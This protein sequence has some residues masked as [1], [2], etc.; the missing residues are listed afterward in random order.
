[1]PLARYALYAWGT[2]I[3][4]AATW[5]RGEPWLSTLRHIAKEGRLFVI[6][7]GMPLR[8][9]DIPDRFAFKQRFYQEA[10]EWINAGD[11]AIVNPDGEFIAG[12]LREAEG[13]LYAEVDPAQMRGP[14][15][16]LDV[17]GHYARPDVFRLT[18]HRDA[19]PILAIHETAATG[20]EVDGEG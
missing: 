6:G 9:A 20:G 12:P 10:G 2:Q 19:R 7:C 8:T 11:S 14:K 17:A 13:L 15:W 4:V 1:M 18:V 16:M 5:D 3:Y